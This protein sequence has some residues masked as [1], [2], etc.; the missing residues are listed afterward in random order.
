MEDGEAERDEGRG[1]QRVVESVER[2][3]GYDLEENL[4][5]IEVWMGRIRAYYRSKKRENV[6]FG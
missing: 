2:E 6:K 3:A 5:T 4:E 1:R